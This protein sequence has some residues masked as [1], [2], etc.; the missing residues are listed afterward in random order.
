MSL[1]RMPPNPEAKKRMTKLIFGAA[2]NV[3]K[4][5]KRSNALAK[6]FNCQYSTQNLVYFKSSQDLLDN[7]L[8]H[9]SV[10]QEVADIH[11]ITSSVSTLYNM[12]A[13]MILAKG[14]EELTDDHHEDIRLISSSAKDTVSADVPKKLETMAKGIFMSGKK[15]QFCSID[16]AEGP[17]WLEKNIPEV[18]TIFQTFIEQNKHRC[19]KEFD[20]ASITWGM[21]PGLVV[22]MLQAILKLTEDVAALGKTNEVNSMTPSQLVAALKNKPSKLTKPILRNLVGRSQ[23]S[24]QSREQTK[25][26]FISVVHEFRLG[27]CHLGNMMAKEGYLPQM[28]LIFYLEIPELTQLLKTRDVHLVKKAMRRQKLLKELNKERYPDLMWGVPE[29]INSKRVVQ[30]ESGT[31]VGR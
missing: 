27:F 17:K 29:P 8:S 9:L 12:L 20:L 26:N 7:I 14:S 4:S 13:I 15:D 5:V 24:V 30:F 1:K 10:L 19:Y 3:K 21:Q 25:S 31:E 16:P 2:W 11:C 6:S 28:D 22:E 18:Y 23:N